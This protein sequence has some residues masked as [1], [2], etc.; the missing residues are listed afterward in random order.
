MSNFPTIPG[1]T[2]L[3]VLGE[4]GMATVYLAV[5]E[6]VGREVA[7]KVMFTSDMADSSFGDRF[8]REARII[9]RLSHPNIV[10]VYDVGKTVNCYY[11]SME[12]LA[13]QDLASRI[14]QGL[15]PAQ[16]LKVTRDIA[17]AL[18]FAHKK[19]Y[20]HRDVKPDNILFRDDGSAVLTDFG[21]A[22][23]TMPDVSMTQ[24]G[25]VIGTPKYMSP[26]QV[27]G[28]AIEASSD[29]YALGIVLYEM[30]TGKVPFDGK[31][32]FDI[33]IRHI[34]D[35]VPRLPANMAVF[36]RLLDGLLA[37][38]KSQRI[39]SGKQVVDAI[40]AIHQV[41]R[42]RAAARKQQKTGDVTAIRPAIAEGADA[43]VKRTSANSE[44]SNTGSVEVMRADSSDRTVTGVEREPA[45]APPAK[46]KAPLLLFLLLILLGGGAAA[47]FYAPQ[48]AADTPLMAAHDA[49][50]ALFVKA[51]K[52]DPKQQKI[53]AA[54]AQ[55][56]AAM[57]EQHYVVP[58]AGSALEF[59]RVVLGLDEFNQQA[60][61]G[62][63]TIAG[64]LLASANQ[65][66]ESN[67]FDQARDYL[68]QAK[69]V[70]SHVPGLMAAEV[71]LRRKEQAMLDA[72][73]Q[74][75]LEEQRLAEE[76]ARQ[77][78]ERRQQQA[79]AERERQKRLQQQRELEAARQAELDRQQAEADAAAALFNN[80][81]IR[82]L[83]AKASTHFSR[84]EYH[85]PVG[86]NALSAYAEVLALD[87]NNAEALDGMNN[88]V[89]KIVEELD[90]LRNEQRMSEAQALYSHVLSIARNKEPL[91]SFAQRA[92][93]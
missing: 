78:E 85:Q 33:G 48:F 30:L 20:V 67:E 61:Q 56:E 65:A 80:V 15:K 14:R 2:I 29:L 47:V 45:V 93:W 84:G 32:A 88:T 73:K 82:G 5:Q 19:G 1:Y 24:V 79:A 36:Q 64:R 57:A 59:Y 31:E 4:G 54:L 49:I 86:E 38:N 51:P 46:S 62:L 8:I 18:D 16:I 28:E 42:Q 63:E 25:K 13:N 6:N 9:A 70:S 60:R 75:L 10:P 26:E 87:T 66:I 76:Q 23:P 44:R 52:I 35:P 22:R 83:L 53:T 55:A 12:Y 91:Y 11:L 71:A 50:K 21:I 90:V 69:N 89:L 27:K 92:G 58:L 72:Q 40:D 81:R 41:L 34:N 7:L 68:S 74:Q 39:Q 77:E 17:S 43:T 37:K 3:R